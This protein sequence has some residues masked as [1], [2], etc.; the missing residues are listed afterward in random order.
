MNGSNARTSVQYLQKKSTKR[1]FMN[2]YK[3]QRIG[4]DREKEGH[5]DGDGD[6]EVF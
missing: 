3:K 2:P 5:G 6:W 4:T 1:S